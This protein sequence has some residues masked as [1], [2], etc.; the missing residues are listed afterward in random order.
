MLPPYHGGGVYGEFFWI[1]INIWGVVGSKKIQK[2][3]NFGCAK[4]GGEFGE[5][6]GNFPARNL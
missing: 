1:C 3:E 6:L 5:F 4:E 2:N